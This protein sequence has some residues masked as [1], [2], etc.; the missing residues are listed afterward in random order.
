[1]KMDVDPLCMIDA[2]MAYII[3]IPNP[4][5]KKCLET[6]I[7]SKPCMLS[8]FPSPIIL[9]TQSTFK[10]PTPMIGFKCMQDIFLTI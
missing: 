7:C 10:S 9:E 1:M 8:C 3:T 4:C 5:L 6:H 2:T